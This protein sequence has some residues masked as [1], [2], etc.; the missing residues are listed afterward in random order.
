VADDEDILEAYEQE[1]DDIAIDPAPMRRSG[2]GFWMVAGT[3]ALGGVVLVVEIFANRPLVNSISRT[4]HDLTVAKR[5]AQQLYADGGTF[6]PAS[7]SGLASVDHGRT[8]VGADTPAVR[9]GTVSVFA[10]SGTWAAAE[11]TP[12]GTCFYVKLVVGAGAKYL[13]AD[14]HCTGREA[15]TADQPQW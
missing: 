14:G 11:R 13:V 7:A 8:Y 1:L 3:I 10:S 2:R 15:L 5:H 12:Q 6:A 4:E 9:P